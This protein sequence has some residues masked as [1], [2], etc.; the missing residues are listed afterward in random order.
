M[1]STKEI[2]I[3]GGGVSGLFASSLLI[4]KG[5]TV[6]LFEKMTGAGKKFLV[7]GYG[8]LNLTNSENIKD[9]SK[10]YGINQKLFSKLLQQFSSDDLRSWAKDL[11]I[12]TF[13]GSSGR[14]FP[15]EMNAATFLRNWQEQL[16]SSQ[17][18]HFYPQHELID[19]E[20]STLT[21]KHLDK[22]IVHPWK[23]ALLFALGG[24]SWSK[25]GSDGKWKK[26][27]EQK[28]IKL[29]EFQAMNCGFNVQ[30]SEYLKNSE[31]FYP[32]KN[33][34]LKHRDKVSSAELMLTPYGFEGGAVY[35][36]SREIQNQ[37]N[38]E[39]EAQIHLDLLP[40]L[41]EKQIYQK[42]TRSPRKK[43]SLSNYL[44]KVLKIDKSKFILLK[45]ILEKDQITNSKKLSQFIKEI[46][47]TITSSRT[48]DE[49]I[50][51]K[52][53]VKMNEVDENL[54]LI[55]CPHI[56]LAGEMLDWDAPTGG[57]LLQGCFSTSYHVVQAILN[58][59]I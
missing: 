23:D 38:S 54:M 14:V 47:I 56:Y 10:R 46:P 39:L 5:H 7:A 40:D 25:T 36:L 18:F 21:L 16:K 31:D 24:A 6:H 34:S 37:L 45:E 41:S 20:G 57:Y 30:W 52:G 42:L 51:T 35:A 29:E 33:I 12:E 2:T 53:G 49:A 58:T 22:T 28:G 3:V 17:N 44:R 11:S 19:F 55:K 15:K 26:L 50:S 27:F 4:A 48:L 43:E 9:F 59:K 8:G 32:L 1:S 13:I